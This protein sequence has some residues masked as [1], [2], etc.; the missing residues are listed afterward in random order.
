MS[1]DQ[2]QKVQLFGEVS[3]KDKL[4]LNAFLA[5]NLFGKHLKQNTDFVKVKKSVMYFG[6]KQKKNN[7]I[8]NQKNSTK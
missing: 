3:F 7:F 6:N 8:H 2:L 5:S 1:F 4:F